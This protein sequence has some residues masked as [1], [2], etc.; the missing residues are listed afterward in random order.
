MVNRI[1]IAINELLKVISE[2]VDFYVDSDPDVTKIAVLLKVYI[3]FSPK[4]LLLSKIENSLIK[5]RYLENYAFLSKSFNIGYI[6]NC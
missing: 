4:H 3:C 1:V 2:L 5:F 6:I